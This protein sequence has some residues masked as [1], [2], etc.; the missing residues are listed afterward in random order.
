M[1]TSLIVLATLVSSA[2]YGQDDGAYSAIHRGA[3][4]T[5]WERTMYETLPSGQM[6]PHKRQY[7]QTAT[8]LNFW[9]PGASQWM[10]SKE[11]IT[12]FLGGAAATNGQH[13]VIF[14]DDLNTGGAIDMEMPDARRLQSHVLGLAYL[15]TASGSNVLIAEIKGCQGVI[16][17]PNRVLYEDAFTDFKAD[18]MYIYTRGG[19]EQDVILRQR[20]PLPEE[21]GLSSASS[22]L[23]VLTEFVSAPTPVVRAGVIPSG[24]GRQM[25]DQRLD[26]GS[27]RIG[28]GRAFTAGQESLEGIP[29]IKEWATLEGRTFL[30]EQVAVAAIAS[31]LEQLPLPPQANLKPSPGSVLHVVSN[32]RLLP[33]RKLAKAG[34]GPMRVASVSAPLSGFVM[35]YTTLNSSQTNYTF[36][37]DT[38]YNLSGSVTLWGTNNTFEGGTVLKYASGVSLTVNTPVTWL[39]DAYRPVV[40]LAK[41]DNASGENISGSSGNPA[42]NYYASKA[43]YF[44]SVIAGTNLVLQNLRVANAETAVIINGKSGHVLDHVQLRKCGNGLAATNAEFAL[45]NALFDRVLTNFTGSSATGRVEHLTADTAIWLNRDIGTNLFLTNC[46]LVA[47]TNLGNCTMQSVSNV[48]SGNGVFQAVGAGAHYL[49]TGSFYRNSGTTNISPSSIATLRGRTTYPPV[50]Y[51]NITLSAVVMTFS[52]QAQRD[53][54]VPDLGYHYDPL[55]YVFGGV[56]ASTNMTFTAGTLQTKKQTA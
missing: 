42:N 45:R 28:A 10:E 50:V 18:V 5:V 9:N 26:F 12:A 13:R 19:F 22:V 11:E 49:A 33:E 51:S 48:S 21:F 16:L 36:K 54:D 7:T 27:M 23:Q 25:T 29:V 15:D 44:D 20:P 55:D 8:G 14:A 3:H 31:E 41:D 1:K 6:V 47:V 2:I 56:S 37:G 52:P 38:T 4:D 32:K 39:S 34:S 40:L 24:V 43:L 17:Q 35:D 30:V 46:L 53:A